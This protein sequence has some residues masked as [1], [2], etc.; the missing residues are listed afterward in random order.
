MDSKQLASLSSHNDTLAQFII[1]LT[2]F[3]EGLSLEADKELRVLRNHLAGKPDFTL[4]SLS[5]RKL[6]T[7]IQ[8]ADTSVKKHTSVTVK[9]LEK[10]IKQYQLAFKDS[11]DIQ[12]QSAHILIAAQQPIN[13]LFQLQAL[14]LKAIK[15][16]SSVTPEQV[17]AL[18]NT[19]K[20]SGA[21]NNSVSAK[22]LFDEIQQEL[23]QLVDTYAR[24]QPT[25][26]RVTDLKFR[27]NTPLTEEELLQTCIQ[28]I[29]LVVNDSMQEAT[30]SGRM[31][32]KVHN[33]L[34]GL[35]DNVDASID[36]T[37]EGYDKRKE[38]DHEFVI[39]L[40]EMEDTV[41]ESGSLE[42]LK[43]EAQVHIK[44]LS[45]AIS[46]R[47]EADNQ[48][49]Q[50]LMSLLNGMQ[51]QLISLQRQTHLYR[52]KLA[53]QTAFS[54]TDP[55]TRLPNR[56]AYNERFSQEFLDAKKDNIPLSLAV[57]DIDYFKSINDRFGHQ[58]GDK[59]LQVVGHH[60]KKQLTGDEFIARWGGEEFVVILPGIEANEL[61]TKLEDM[62]ASL[63]GLPFKFKQEKISITASFGGTC[64]RQDDSTH[65][66][67]ERADEL[68]Y[69]AKKNGR[70]R[71][72]VC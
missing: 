29:R 55:L 20:G 50:A 32:H 72:E 63:A 9:E 40:H 34:G 23:N 31:V 12:K 15:L 16:F 13:D 69:Q 57:I 62:R 51:S 21:A 18:S 42:K 71:V 37:R 56:L 38:R 26:Q 61:A 41:K 60:F 35:K 54:H 17:D 46:E 58:A 27:L 52:R 8:N 3:Y 45:Q 68:L 48:Q 7:L 10:Q 39:Q 11:K 5:I 14:C 1:R 2:G 64:I 70:N 30:L 25:E 19:E 28:V 67:F 43:A 44:A 22:H 4:A 49:Q 36:A 66:V 53:E 59:T 6:N 47:K 33:A 65:Q 24:K